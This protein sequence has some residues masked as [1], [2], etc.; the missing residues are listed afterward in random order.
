[1]S[2]RW[3][4]IRTGSRGR[5]SFFGMD[6]I[7]CLATEWDHASAIWT[8]FRAL[9][10]FQGIWQGDRAKAPLVGPARSPSKTAIR[11]RH[12]PRR[13]ERDWASGVIEN[14]ERDLKDRF[15]SPSFEER[16]KDVAEV[17][18]LV[19]GVHATATVLGSQRT[20]T[21]RR[22]RGP[23]ISYS[24]TH[25]AFGSSMSNE[26]WTHLWSRTSTQIS[27][28]STKRGSRLQSSLPHTQYIANI[29]RSS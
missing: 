18:S 13:A 17:R 2:R 24:A 20:A 12:F 3:I 14:Y 29:L 10:P 26:R 16:L 9:G 15:P 23:L 19:H 11:D 22:A 28:P 7:T 21:H 1:M 8:A 25:L 4:R 5:L 27:A 6:A